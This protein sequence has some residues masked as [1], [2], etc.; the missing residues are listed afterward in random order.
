MKHMRFLPLLAVTLIFTSCL[1]DH[2][3]LDPAQS[4]VVIEF[5]NTGANVSPAGAVYARFASDLGSLSTG[6]SASFN[7]NLNYA[8]AATAQT[9]ITVTLALD[10]AA[11]TAYNTDQHTSYAIPPASV[12]H[13]PTTGVIKKGTQSLQIKVAITNTT[14]FDFNVNYALPVKIS[15]VSTGVISGNYGTAIYSFAVRNVY[16]GIYEMTGTMVDA[17]SAALTG[18]YPV[19]VPLITYTGNSIALWDPVYS[20]AYGHVIRSGTG[21]SV[22]GTFSPV[23]A[24]DNA[25]NITVTNYFGS[26]AG[27]NKRN[28]VLDPAGINKITYGAD[29]HVSYFEV[30]YAMT[31]NGATRT[32]FVEKFTYV[33]PR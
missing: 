10:E 19:E 29:G 21:F 5:A 8:G 22:Y 24:F 23:F 9:D 15:T 25:G 7:I 33:K 3:A 4:P 26:A 30:S 1:K 12:F 32:T 16:D 31:Q 17:T 11:L 28:A 2:L 27:A 13:L 18:Y 6:D 14:D 20:N